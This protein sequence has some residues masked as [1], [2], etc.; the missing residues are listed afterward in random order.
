M[1]GSPFYKLVGKITERLSV[2]PESKINCSSKKTVDNLRNISLDQDEVVISF[3][4]TP[5]YTNVPVKEGIH[6]PAEN[7]YYAKFSVPPV[8]KETFIILAELATN[9]VVMLTHDVPYR[10]IDGLAMSSQPAAPLLTIRSSKYES[11]TQDYAKRFERYMGGILRIIKQA[12]L[13]K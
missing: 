2:I 6:A 5:L 11:S 9:N 10:Q 8:D 7:F 13:W 3:N 4:V 1:L 12:S